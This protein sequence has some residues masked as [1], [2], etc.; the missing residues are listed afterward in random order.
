MDD[1]SRCYLPVVRW[2]HLLL[3][4]YKCN[5]EDKINTADNSKT[6]HLLNFCLI[7]LTNARSVHT[8]LQFLTEQTKTGKDKT[9]FLKVWGFPPLIVIKV[10]YEQN[11]EAKSK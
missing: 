10:D 7:S 1:S 6:D 4:T 8:A 2:K 3:Y 9:K 5:T 11:K